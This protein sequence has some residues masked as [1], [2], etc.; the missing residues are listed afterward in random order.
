MI[1]PM[2]MISC[3]GDLGITEQ[4]V[5]DAGADDTDAVG[6]FLVEIGEEPAVREV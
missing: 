2:G 3:A 6:Q 1:S 5:A 4:L